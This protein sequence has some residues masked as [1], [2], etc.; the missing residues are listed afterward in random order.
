[1]K[2]IGLNVFGVFLVGLWLMPVHIYAQA[3]TSLRVSPAIIEIATKPGATEQSQVAVTNTSK[4]SLPLSFEVRSLYFD[5]LDNGTDTSNFDG[6]SWIELDNKTVIF[7]AGESKNIPLHFHVPAAASPGG[8]Y[9]QLSVRSLLLEK[10]ASATIVIPEV[11]VGIFMT[12]AGDSQQSLEFSSSNIVPW[13]MAP[14]QSRMLTVRI[15]NDGNVHNIV[16]PELVGR[17]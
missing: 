2:R 3:E 11:S 16:T 1:M 15:H 4:T 5:N 6:S 7:K 13:Q 8:H 17:K 10:K 9:A 12:V 14:N